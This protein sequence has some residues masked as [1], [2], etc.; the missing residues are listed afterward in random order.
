MLWSLISRTYFPGSEW[1]ESG[2]EA[3]HRACTSGHVVTSPHT[4][5]RP[6]PLEAGLGGAGGG[7]GID[8]M[9]TGPHN[10][11]DIACVSLLSGST[12]A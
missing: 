1:A 10:L 2:R 5:A 6:R 8:R 12:G 4:L 3:L 11:A 7:W 9:G